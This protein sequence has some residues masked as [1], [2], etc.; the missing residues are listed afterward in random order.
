MID[1][2]N[3]NNFYNPDEMSKWLEFIPVIKQR[4]LNKLEDL[5]DKISNEEPFQERNLDI[6]DLCILGDELEKIL[7]RWNY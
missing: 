2:P 5:S 1:N 7:N 4:I 6:D 3:P